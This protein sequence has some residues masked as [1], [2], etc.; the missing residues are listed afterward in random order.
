MIIWINGAFGSG[1]STT[2]ELLHSK[3]EKSHIYDPE[4]VGYFL[5]DSFPDNMKKKGDF[6]DIELWR[7]MNYQIIK[8]MYDNYDGIIII[9]MTIT[10]KDYYDE[11]I[12]KLLK[13]KINVYHFILTAE[14]TKIKERLIARGECE[15][16]WPEMQIDRCI[17]AFR[18]TIKGI[19]INTDNLSAAEAVDAILS[20]INKTFE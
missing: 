6:Q 13:D 7:S 18:D 5:W 17:R 11:I 14:K 20:Y 1:K 8:H 2:A 12:G 4:Q 9:P 3:I 10:N 16:S 19:Q 15:N